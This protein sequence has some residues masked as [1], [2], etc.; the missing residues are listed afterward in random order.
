MHYNL[1]RH[2][3]TYYTLFLPMHNT[4]NPTPIGA[5]VVHNVTVRV[6]FIYLFFKPKHQRQLG[7]WVETL[8]RH[9]ANRVH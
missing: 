7:E 9:L 1:S 8:R 2:I 3:Y 6:Y 5:R 4:P